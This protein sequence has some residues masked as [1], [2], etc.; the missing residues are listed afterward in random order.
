L[1]PIK[2]NKKFKTMKKQ[3]LILVAAV[4]TAALFSCSKEKIERNETT[5]PG[6]VAAKKPGGGG[7]G[8]GTLN[9][10]L[11]GWYRFDSSLVD[12]TGQLA[13]GLSNV[14]RVLYT[15]DRKG[16]ANN[17]ILFNA[18]YGVDIFDVPSTPDGASISVWIKHDTLPSPG[19]LCSVFSF[20]GFIIQQSYD[21]FNASYYTGLFG[22]P[23]N[24]YSSSGI[25][26]HWHHMVAT[27]DNNELKFYIDGVLMGTAPTPAGAGPYPT[28]DN[29]LLGY[30][31]DNYWKG[32]LDDLRFYK[33]VLT[34]SEITQLY[35]L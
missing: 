10:G 18:G 13:D 7:S 28:A 35:N 34:T 9:K 8:S 21:Y 1:E 26:K 17:A 6:E 14:R 33:R 11:L 25:D 30:A 23:P 31:Y 19:W 22:T 4:M 3:I 29:Y 15:T 2:K 12:A 20:K 27:R 16:V 32:S 5:N 24:V